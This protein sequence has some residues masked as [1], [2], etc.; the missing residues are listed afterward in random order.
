MPAM[1]FSAEKQLQAMEETCSVL[2]LNHKN[3]KPKEL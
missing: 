2:G 3:V 1:I